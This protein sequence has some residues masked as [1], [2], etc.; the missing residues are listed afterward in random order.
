M[1][2]CSCTRAVRECRRVLH[3]GH[4]SGQ[5]TSLYYV[6]LSFSLPPSLSLAPSL[7]RPRA[8]SRA[9]SALTMESENS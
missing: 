1:L 4:S 7:P 8:F 2:T 9:L 6:L 5:N 3:R